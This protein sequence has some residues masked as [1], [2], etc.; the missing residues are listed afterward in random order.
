MFLRLVQKICSLLLFLLGSRR[1]SGL[2]NIPESGPY[3]VV[4][5][6]MGAADIPLVYVAMP[7]DQIEN[8]SFFIGEKWEKPFFF[9]PLMRRAGGI[10]INR[11]RLDRK[12]LRSAM[13]AI[14]AGAIFGLAPEGT[15]SRVGEMIEARDGA[16]YL[17]SRTNVPILPIGLVNTDR[18]WPNL[19]RLR[20]TAFELHVGEPFELPDL[21]RRPKGKD[22]NAYT[23]LIMVE[24]AA[25]IPAR[26]HGFYKDSP[27]LAARLR[28]E[29]PWPY[30]Q[31]NI[32][33]ADS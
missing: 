29:D 18:A 28:G 9:G 17:A 6:H 12:A 21:G 25:L 13:E 4:T 1:L 23:E 24:I 10:Y 15:R 11:Y 22:L 14:K 2:E 7:S 31:R 8:L 19:R 3:L 30:C 16:A 27:A 20:R 33:Q 5:N 26:Y 32:A